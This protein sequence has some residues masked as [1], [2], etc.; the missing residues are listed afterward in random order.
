ML[1]TFY[2][3]HFNLAAVKR[4]KLKM[5]SELLKLARIVEDESDDDPDA[6]RKKG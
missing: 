6:E 2:G 3:V 1:G 5:S 4:A